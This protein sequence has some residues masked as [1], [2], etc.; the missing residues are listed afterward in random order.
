MNDTQEM[1]SLR[2]LE[3]KPQEMQQVRSDRSLIDELKD[4]GVIY[5]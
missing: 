4:A 3:Q 2:L 5:R 1:P